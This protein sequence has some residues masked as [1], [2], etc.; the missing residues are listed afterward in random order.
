MSTR[1]IG[2]IIGGGELPNKAIEKLLSSKQEFRVVALNGFTEKS[3]LLDKTK[4]IFVKLGQAGKAIKFLKQENVNDILMIGNV[5]RPSLTSLIPDLWTAKFLAKVGF[6]SLGDDGI[7]KAIS[8]ELRLEGF[9]LIG[10][11]DILDDVIAKKGILGK[12]KPN[13]NALNDIKRG[14]AVLKALSPLDI[15]QGVIV[16]QGLILAV[17]A[18]EGTDKM[19]ERTKTLIREGNKP[20]LIKMKKVNQH[21]KLD[22]PTVGSRTVINAYNCGL[23]GIAIHSGNS[24]VV[25]FDEMV[26]RADELGLF[27]YGYD[28]E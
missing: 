10:I 20:I 28:D 4:H 2:L 22:L 8:D 11:Q 7:L 27:I 24:L 26:K 18:I 23:Q 16:Q 14:I 17:E 15:G 19:L 5:K 21:D 13:E 1:I 25:D 12:H 3:P 9:N 6:K